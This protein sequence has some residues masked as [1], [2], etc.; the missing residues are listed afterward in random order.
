MEADA[1]MF[2][3]RTTPTKLNVLF[4]HTAKYRPLGAGPWVHSLI[5]RKLDRSRVAVHVALHPG[6]AND[7]APLFAKL[8]SV[9]NLQIYPVDLGPES[10]QIAARNAIRR[11]FAAMASLGRV[12]SSFLQLMRVVSRNKIGIIHTDERPRDAVVSV[13]LGKITAAKVILH[14]HVKY[15]DWMSPLLKWSLGRADLVVCVSN[16]VAQS[17]IDAGFDP[18]RVRTVLNS[19]DISEWTGPDVRKEV[20]D[21]LQLPPDEP[22]VISVC[23]LGKGKGPLEL[24]QA[25]A[26][27]RRQHPNLRLIIVGQGSQEFVDRLKRLIAELELGQNVILTGYRGDVP[28]LMRAADIYAMPSDGEPFGL[29]FLEAMA[30][31]LP[32]IALDNGGTPEVVAN[33]VTGLLSPLGDVE[34][35]A[36]NL[37]TV[38]GDVDLRKT[39]G[40][41]GRIRARECFDGPRLADDIMRIYQYLDQPVRD[42]GT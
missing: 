24:V 4:I 15:D 23:R 8:K 6:A 26:I 19:I 29:V 5:M 10:L 38:V 42:S 33:G 32:V 41:A 22:V 9:S 1:T 7:E 27:V 36:V 37:Q 17:L 34:S 21:E 20:R 39:L 28:R 35:L 13:L 30:S 16:F 40:E 3:S 14:L 18:A 25:V 31:G 11:P 12:S 2:N